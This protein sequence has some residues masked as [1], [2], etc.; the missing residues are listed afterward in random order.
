MAP[1]RFIHMHLPHAP[2]RELPCQ[3]E[4][5]SRDAKKFCAAPNVS[6]TRVAALLMCL[7]ARNGK[8]EACGI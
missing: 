3:A 8:N 6:Q 5:L 4:D 1:H 2:R 7:G